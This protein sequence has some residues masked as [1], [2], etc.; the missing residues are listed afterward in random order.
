MNDMVTFLAEAMGNNPGR[1]IHPVL[2]GVGTGTFGPAPQLNVEGILELLKHSRTKRS[3]LDGIG[4]VGGRIG[5][6]YG[7]VHDYTP[8][9]KIQMGLDQGQDPKTLIPELS[10]LKPEVA[11]TYARLLNSEQFGHT[12]KRSPGAF[13][14][15]IDVLS[16]PSY[17]GVNFLGEL[18]DPKFSKASNPL[19]AAGKGLWGTE[20]ASTSQILK[21]HNILQG[22]N[23]LSKWG[24]AGLSFAGD[25]LL[26]P[27]TYFFGAGA[28]KNIGTKAAIKGGEVAGLADRIAEGIK[29]YDTEA[30]LGSRIYEQPSK[31]GLFTNRGGSVTG[32]TYTEVAQPILDKLRHPTNP[33]L[34]KKEVGQLQYLMENLGLSSGSHAMNLKSAELRRIYGD[35]LDNGLRPKTMAQYDSFIDIIRQ[36]GNDAGITGLLDRISR[37]DKVV[38]N[39]FQK[40]LAAAHSL[41]KASL[42]TP[43]D[44]Q[45]FL[46]LKLGRD[47]GDAEANKLYKLIQDQFDIIP[48]ERS[49]LPTFLG[50]IER[51]PA[52]GNFDE[53]INAVMHQMEPMGPGNKRPWVG[54]QQVD[55][56]SVLEHFMDPQSTLG[57]KAPKA[58]L[59]GA[60]NWQQFLKTIRSQQPEFWDEIISHGGTEN[61]RQA[62]RTAKSDEVMA[63]LNPLLDELKALPRM[64]QME[65]HAGIPFTKMRASIQPFAGKKLGT[66]P[67]FIPGATESLRKMKEQPFNDVM[68]YYAD[69]GAPGPFS[70]AVVKGWQTWDKHFRTAN[71]ED[72]SIGGVQKLYN[73]HAAHLK[74]SAANYVRE[75]WDG[76]SKK[77]REDL[78]HAWLT[79][80]DKFDRLIENMTNKKG[81]SL[82][83]E[84]HLHFEKLAENLKENAALLNRSKIHNMGEALSSNALTR[85][86]IDPVFWEKYWQE[87]HPIKG[88]HDLKQ[89]TGEHLQNY[90]REQDKFLAGRHSKLTRNNFMNKWD[91]AENM[92]FFGNG[93]D[94]W[95]NRR[96]ML[97]AVKEF[98]VNRN[99]KKFEPNRPKGITN[100]PEVQNPAGASIIE[101][102][103]KQGRPMREINFED[104]RAKQSRRYESQ[105]KHAVENFKGTH[106]DEEMIPAIA[107]MIEMSNP[108]T[109]SRN[110]ELYMAILQKWKKFNTIYAIPR[111]HM[112]N[113]FSDVV[114]NHMNGLDPGPRSWTTGAYRKA[115]Q[116]L[117]PKA[118]RDDLDVIDKLL[119]PFSNLAEPKA[120]RTGGGHQAIATQ[121]PDPYELL[122]QNRTL[123]ESSPEFSGAAFKPIIK[124]NKEQAA[125]Y[126]KSHLD[127][128]D[129]NAL[130]DKYGLRSHFINEDIAKQRISGSRGPF[131]GK[132]DD[133][134]VDW[135]GR[136]ENFFRMGNFIHSI[137]DELKKGHGLDTA[138]EKAADRVNKFNFDYSD[139][140]GF[141]KDWMINKIFP[142]YKWSRKAI[143]LLLTQMFQNPRIY[144]LYNHFNNAIQTGLQQN[145]QNNL[146]GLPSWTDTVP[147]W[148]LEAGAYPFA[149][150][151]GDPMFTAG[152]PLPWTDTLSFLNKV[153]IN[154]DGSAQGLGGIPGGLKDLVLGLGNPGLKALAGAMGYQNPAMPGGVSGLDNVSKELVPG[155]KGTDWLGQLLGVLGGPANA[156]AGIAKLGS[157]NQTQAQ[158]GGYGSDY[159]LNAALINYLTGTPTY[160][161]TQPR[162]LSAVQELNDF[163]TRLNKGDRY[164]QGIRD[165]YQFTRENQTWNDANNRTTWENIMALLGGK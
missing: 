56:D 66:I 165:P 151:R 49:A 94:N 13:S 124:L 130:Y 116:A 22:N 19:S 40:K 153:G 121:A 135:S 7:P 104:F 18:L 76:I 45:K 105:I 63:T 16:R 99:F 47:V 111:Y 53:T 150:E 115:I 88:W 39:R 17:M 85:Y 33:N 54:K 152:M 109:M 158:I 122:Q 91:L 4:P 137:E 86:G 164:S 21:Q 73:S 67:R 78:S 5:D 149:D 140:T 90:F 84:F 75:I 131:K 36:A 155:E 136:R 77:D 83:T 117:F 72:T 163:V 95:G 1:P 144:A 108:K 52:L 106:F 34:T 127:A 159:P 50:S 2:S 79:D 139:F 59:T 161:N 132:V 146:N 9:E 28:V 120:G 160:Q 154:E 15:V 162:Q 89:L 12:A 35:I 10:K 80:K 98:G 69:K 14:R 32:K 125:K 113:N 128:A 43:E 60:A 46:E 148:L 3:I 126:G 96:A 68:R 102:A 141:E 26:D 92:Y 27:T 133:K 64:K 48:G 65:L 145:D 29:T 100:Y 70:K 11:S 103:A 58:G 37:A 112:R 93:I 51:T 30:N 41:G 118:T 101:S 57:I 147:S 119:N 142:F 31:R 23:F 138:A 71:M 20:K 87:I 143:P 156:A 25:V 61:L 114:M 123:I 74:D 134:L 81:Q 38:G 8:E 62:V 44:L 110:M 97:E 6:L 55:L 107:R 82:K 24:K 129:I 42:G 157:Y